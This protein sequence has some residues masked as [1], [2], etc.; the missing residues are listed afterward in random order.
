MGCFV[1]LGCTLI[2]NRP[3]PASETFAS[4]SGLDEATFKCFTGKSLA[5]LTP[6]VLRLGASPCCQNTNVG[7]IASCWGMTAFKVNT[8][9]V[10]AGSSVSTVTVFTCVPVR[11]PMLKVAVISPLSPGGT[12]SFWVCAAVQPQEVRTD[13]NRTGLL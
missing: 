8:V 10:L 9:V 11:S 2:L 12:S 6:I 4:K 1:S 5:A 7:V 13:L 3:L